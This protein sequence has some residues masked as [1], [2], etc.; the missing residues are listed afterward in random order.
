MTFLKALCGVASE[1]CA[2]PNAETRMYALN[3]VALGASNVV[4]D[5]G[6]Y[7][8]DGEP[9]RGQLAT[10]DAVREFI[11]AGRAVFTLR[12]LK[13][14]LRYTYRVRV[15]KGDVKNGVPADPGEARYF[16]ETLRGADNTRDYRYVGVLRRPGVL[17][18]TAAS[19][20]SRS[21]PSSVAL[22]WFL[23]RMKEGRDGVLG[24]LVEFWHEGRCCRCGRALTVPASVERGIGPECFGRGRA[25]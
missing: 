2:A 1:Q 22:V 23:G 21:A 13:T 25:A 8:I 24:R 6:E 9:R 17:W 12:S 15:R 18:F 11:F 10:W 14:G 4:D 5:H 7:R 20:Q 19:R 3:P 16:V